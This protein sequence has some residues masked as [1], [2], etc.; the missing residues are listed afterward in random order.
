M[1]T[2]GAAAAAAAALTGAA[3]AAARP[4]AAAARAD[5]P[6]PP[7]EAPQDMPTAAPASEERAA[8][9]VAAFLA[10]IRT[11]EGTADANGYRALFGHTP[12]R[13]RLFDSFADH[14]RLAQ[15]FT[16][17]AGRRLWTS[18]AGAYQFMAKSPI[19][20]TTRTTQ[21]D[22]WDRIAAA[23]QLPDFSP[24]SQD[25]AAVELIRR[26]GALG[27]VRAGRFAHAVAKVRAEW[28]SL[29]GA[30][31]DQPERSLEAVT[32]AYLDAGGSL[33]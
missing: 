17:A 12:R 11:A 15:Q 2:Q 4:A 5:A 18:A 7:P 6:E 13:P 22:T 32:A 28:A 10:M 14:P 31:Y 9:N 26:R 20:G 23:L 16:D 8:R 25:A 3:L 30:G 33:A 21:V 19:P 24:A 27:D 29:P 1:N